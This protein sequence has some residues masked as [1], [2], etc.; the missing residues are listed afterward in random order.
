M[1]SKRIFQS[2]QCK[3]IIIIIIH[4]VANYDMNYCTKTTFPCK[5]HN[6]YNKK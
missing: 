6:T 3:Y 1:T 2:L 4:F 5:K